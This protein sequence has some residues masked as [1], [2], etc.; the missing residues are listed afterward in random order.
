MLC[1][2]C[3]SVRWLATHLDPPDSRWCFWL[4]TKWHHLVFHYICRLC[5]FT[6]DMLTQRSQNCLPII[7]SVER[8]CVIAWTWKTFETILGP[9]GSVYCHYIKTSLSIAP[10]QTFWYNSRFILN[11]LYFLEIL[12]FETKVTNVWPHTAQLQEIK[13]LRTLNKD[14]INH[15]EPDL[16]Q[17]LFSTLLIKDQLYPFSGSR[18]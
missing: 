3:I 14:M 16:T 1:C 9:V 11:V 13:R 10:R 17:T 5:Y 4:G 2:L 8:W 7:F 18:F 15:S 12:T 6:D